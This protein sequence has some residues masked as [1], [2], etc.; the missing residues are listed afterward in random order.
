MS[1]VVADVDGTLLNSDKVLTTRAK[2]AVTALHAAS[3]D[4][5]AAITRIRGSARR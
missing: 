1:L 5:A 3:S 2:A 4:C